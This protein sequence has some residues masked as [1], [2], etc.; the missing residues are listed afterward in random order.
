MAL[1]VDAIELDVQCASDGT[2]V[3]IH[4]PALERTTLGH[5]PVGM[6]SAAELGATPLRD[7]PG[8]HVPTLD[9]VLD[10]LRDGPPE[11]HLEIKADHVGRVDD[12]LITGLIDAIARHRLGDR[13]IVTCF[14][15]T[16]LARVRARSPQTRLLASIDRRTAETYGGTEA[17]LDRFTALPGCL[18]AVEKTLLRDI[19]PICLER[20]GGDRLGAWV[21]N[22]P[23]DIDYWM[24]QPIR[25]ITTDRPDLALAARR[26]LGDG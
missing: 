14:V 16:V 18:I 9:E 24:R 21:A 11:L 3:V 10:V 22:D 25:Q 7:A 17:T 4:D 13:A 12:R 6:K 15:P 23:E 26:V 20:I 8:D 2:L 19:L 1:G 5:G